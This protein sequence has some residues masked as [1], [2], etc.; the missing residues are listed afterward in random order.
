MGCVSN[1][2]APMQCN[3]LAEMKGL[4]KAGVACFGQGKR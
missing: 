3:L 4:V 1:Y 2:A